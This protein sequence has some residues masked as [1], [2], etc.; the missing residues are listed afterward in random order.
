MAFSI[1]WLKNNHLNNLN[2]F[3]MKK[4]RQQLK[5]FN[6]YFGMK[7]YMKSQY[8]IKKNST[9]VLLYNMTAKKNVYI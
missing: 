3:R 8:F 5:K 6:K 4:F 7:L 9:T 1:P 2:T